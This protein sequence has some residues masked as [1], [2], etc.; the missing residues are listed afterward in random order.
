M[1]NTRTTT[2]PST[3]DLN[4][5]LAAIQTSIEHINRNINKLLIFQQFTTGERLT[6][7]E[8]TSNRGGSGSQYGRLTKFEFPKFY[9]YDV[10]GWLYRVNQFFLL[11]SKADDQKVMLVSMHMFDKALNWIVYENVEWIVYERE[12]QKRFNSVFED[13]M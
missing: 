3:T 8:G 12:V 11:D 7:G 9:G 6:N 4:N 13:L 1:V 2:D 10:Q 5:T